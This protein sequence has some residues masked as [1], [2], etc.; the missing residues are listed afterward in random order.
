LI[1]WRQG[2]GDAFYRIGSE[3]GLLI[4]REEVL[5]LHARIEPEIQAEAFRS[6]GEVLDLT[7]AHIASALGFDVP[8]NRRHFLSRSLPH[9]QPFA[10]TATA[11]EK[12]A[13]AGYRL[14]ILSNVDDELLRGTLE[15][16][17]VDFDLLVTAEQVGSYKPDPGHF[18]EARRRTA[19]R[20]WLHVAQSLFHDVEPAVTEDVPVVWINRLREVRS[21]A[22][23][24]QAEF[25]DMESF[26]EQLVEG[27]GL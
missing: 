27:G 14:G 16:F 25:P 19:G 8:T 4:D 24:P 13:S 9:W 10:D 11:L 6:Y 1:D 17:P 7:A 12:L 23:R 5:D 3:I 2:I 18:R 26:A 15:H 22:H 21:G 20:R